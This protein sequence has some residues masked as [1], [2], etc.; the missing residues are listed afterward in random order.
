MS[1]EQIRNTWVTWF[2]AL[3]NQ[4]PNTPGWHICWWHLGYFK[5]LGA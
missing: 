4:K 5:S 1:E 3:C 2:I